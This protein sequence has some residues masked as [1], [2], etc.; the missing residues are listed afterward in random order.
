MREVAFSIITP[1]YNR[2]VCIKELIESVLLQKYKNWE[3]ILVDDG[4]TDRTG[5]LCKEYVFQDSRIRY[6]FQKNS[7][8]CVARNIG[9]KEAKGNYILFLDSDNTLKQNALSM[10]SSYILSNKEVDMYCFGYDTLI[11]EWK[12]HIKE[13]V[14]IINKFEIRNV[15]LPMHINIISQD[16][17]FIKN[18]VWNKCYR[19]NFL[20][21]NQIVFDENRR[22]WEDGLFIVDCLDSADSIIL[23]KHVIYN[24]YSNDD[25]EHLSSKI[26]ENQLMQYIHDEKMFKERF[27]QD[28]IFE[29]KHYCQSNFQVFNMLCERTI[30]V[31]GKRAKDIVCDVLKEE[32]VSFWIF[33]IDL[34]NKFEAYLKKNMK[35]GNLNKIFFFY[36]MKIMKNHLCRKLGKML[37][38]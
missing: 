30:E 21:C 19:T 9:I 27:G 32:I 4:S 26:F 14:K 10:L 2:E 12:P 24:A 23:L 15:Y 29:N 8:V 13:D 11:S 34:N 36:R 3:L 37:R 20:R 22:T 25:V 31:Y 33:N 7:G 6:Y 18:F 5:E 1:V 17:R 35:E 28:Y 16:A 38:R